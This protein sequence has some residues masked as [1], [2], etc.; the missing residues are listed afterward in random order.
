MQF[1]RAV[2]AFAVLLSALVTRG[3]P[4]QSPPAVTLGFGVDTT[5]ADVAAIVRTVSA[6]F[7]IRGAGHAYTPYWSA[8]EQEERH[9]YDLTADFVF[10]GFGATIAAVTPTG[11]G[12]EYVVRTLFAHADSNGASIRP[13]ALQR[14]YAG[15]NPTGAW[16]L[17]SALPHLTAGWVTRDVKFITYHMPAGWRFDEEK[18]QRA[19]RFLDSAAHSVQVPRPP[20]IDY[21][22]AA[23]TEDMYRI[24]GLDYFIQVSGPAGARGGKSF[25][26]DGIIISGD[27]ELGEAYLHELAHVAIGVEFP[28]GTRNTLLN[29]GF[30]TWMGGSRNRS[31]AQM[32]QGLVAYQNANPKVDFLHLIGG[33]AG[34]GWGSD[35]TD[36]LYATGALIFDVVNTH[37]GVWGIKKLLGV[38]GR[39]N[40]AV[41]PELR[42][43]LQIFQSMDDWWRTETIRASK[44]LQP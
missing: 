21:Y 14:L 32:I 28:E 6:Y 5:Q 13:V 18:A 33:E 34:P 37:F 38:R 20:H 8:R 39:P 4:G 19:A 7:R 3:A 29:E 36:A 24:I 17:S 43:M 30:A 15:R 27:P 9:D 16:E 35:D 31:Y 42:E 22:L 40:R 23:S 11:S 12:G 2:P 10:Q 1:G 25:P 41:E 26:N 44:R